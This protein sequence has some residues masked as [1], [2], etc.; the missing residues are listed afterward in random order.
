MNALVK[1][2]LCVLAWTACACGADAVKLEP[3]ARWQ[4]SFPDL[5]KSL[6]ALVSQNQRPPQLTVWLPANYS[7]TGRFPV[8]LILDGDDGG[9]GD[10]LPL[11]P[12]T[13]G[14][15]DFIY[16]NLPLFKRTY[17]GTNDSKIVMMEDYQT[18]SH[19]YRVM[20]QKLF[21][22][23]PNI[24]P[25]RSAFGGFSNGAHALGVLLA[26]QD[27]FLLQHFQSFY[28]IEG[29]FGSLAA[30]V[31]APGVAPSLKGSRI[32]LMYGDTPLP[33]HDPTLS[34][35]YEH[36]GRAC[37]LSAQRNHLDL[38]LV[39]MRGFGHELPPKYDDV[40]GMWVRGE[41]LPK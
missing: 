1:V 35:M 29:G 25:E 40:L 32:L 14:S 15:N 17:T 41:E 30:S 9:F 34:Q 12:G 7:R 10:R 19:T 16:V 6:A 39:V 27:S 36:L 22:T 3:T 26:R 20:L 38:S 28:L 21:E 33:G 23:V 18:M 8:F 13:V 37:V 31:A 5:P 2:S 4:M 11:R 24:T